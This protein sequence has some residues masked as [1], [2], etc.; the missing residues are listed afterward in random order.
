MVRR[1]PRLIGC[2]RCVVRRR[3]S[4]ALLN[5]GTVDKIS[6][7]CSWPVFATQRNRDGTATQ[8]ARSQLSGRGATNLLSP[9]QRKRKKVKLPKRA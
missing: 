9:N 7:F 5:N 6:F 4:L 2:V 8:Y 1:L 3:S